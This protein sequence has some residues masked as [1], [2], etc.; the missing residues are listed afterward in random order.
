M[1]GRWPAPGWKLVLFAVG[2]GVVGPSRAEAQQYRRF[3]AGAFLGGVSVN[4]DLGTVSNLFFTTTGQSDNVSF[5]GDFFGAR[6][7]YDFI[8]NLAAEATY[9]RAQQTFSFEVVD[10]IEADNVA[11]GDQ[12]DAT[13]QNI[14]GNVVAQFPLEIGLVPYGTIGFA[15][16]R[17]NLKNEIAGVTSDSSNGLNFGGG[18]KYFFPGAPWVGARFDL[19]YQLL[20]EGLAFGDNLVE[21]R[22]TE[23]TIGVAFRF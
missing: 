18:A 21:P 14:S 8:P 1:S 3:E 2:I 7:S 20:S 6:F 4:H 11:L 23:V 9:S 19:R 10:D 17:T 22:N 13:V 15:W 5:G 16:V 12:F